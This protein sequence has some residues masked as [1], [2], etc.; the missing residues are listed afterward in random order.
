MEFCAKESDLPPIICIQ[1]LGIN[2]NEPSSVKIMIYLVY[3][4]PQ[5]KGLETPTLMYTLTKLVA[6]IGNYVNAKSSTEV[7]AT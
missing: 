5:N 4:V 3:L 7:A 6:K 2:L 1:R